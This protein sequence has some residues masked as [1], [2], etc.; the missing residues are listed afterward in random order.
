MKIV[1]QQLFSAHN[2]TLIAQNGHCGI[3]YKTL[4]Q[5]LQSEEMYVAAHTLTIIVQGEKQI[6]GYDGKVYDIAENTMVFMPKDLYVVS[7]LLPN[8]G[9]FESY[10]LFFDDTLIERYLA[11]VNMPTGPADVREIY[12][13][14]Y[15]PAMQTY[16]TNLS[17]LFGALETDD[18]PLLEIKLFEALRLTALADRSGDFHAWLNGVL[19]KSKRDLGQFMQSHYDKPLRVENFADLTGRSVS[20]FQRDFK[21]HFGMTPKKWLNDRRLEKAHALMLEN[22]ISVTEVAQ[23]TGYENISHFIKMFKQKYDLSPK[24]FLLQNRAC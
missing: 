19:R 17:P 5:P 15:T 24:Q 7:D 11:A 9:R 14:D 1:P 13:V 23:E 2:V 12:P 20:T 21:R 4:N 10:L 8:Q 3:I 16:A 18:T 6:S 22:D